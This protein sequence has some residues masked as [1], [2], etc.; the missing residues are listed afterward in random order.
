MIE[1]YTDGSAMK[2]RSG[3]GFVVVIDGT[4]VYEKAGKEQVGDTNQLMELIAAMEACDWA[5]N[6]EYYEDHDITIYSDSA[7]LT[8]CYK[9]KWYVNWENNGW[10][11]SKGETVANL[12]E[13]R[14]L[15]KMFKNPKINF[16]KVKAHC[17]HLYNER[18][19][20][21]ATGKVHPDE[22]EHLTKDK[23]NDIIYI[24]LSEI[25]LNYSMKK[26]DTKTTIEMIMR[27]INE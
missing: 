11:N 5:V 17:G 15:V 2:N 26:I 27:L 9:D 21:L 18:A 24:K 19:D 10:K 25:L 23:K 6:S 7:Y 20:A 22:C 4:K 13:W 14:Y 12:L 1:I 8:N 16:E 3:W